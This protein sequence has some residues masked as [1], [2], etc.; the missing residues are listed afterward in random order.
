MKNFYS[1]YISSLGKVSVSA[2]SLMYARR[3]SECLALYE[4]IAE[5]VGFEGFGYR[6]LLI[7]NFCLR[8]MG[9]DFELE[10][11]IGDPPN[12]D[13]VGHL[14]NYELIRERSENA[15]VG[16]AFLAQPKVLHKAL[17]VSALAS[18]LGCEEIIETG[19]FLGESAYIFSGSVQTVT[20]IEADE[21]LHLTSRQWL[22]RMKSGDKI[23]CLCGDSGTILPDLLATA[24]RKLM[25]F[26]DAHFSAGITSKRF[27]ETPLE[28]ELKSIFIHS[29][30]SIVVIDD[31]RLMAKPGYPG[32]ERMFQLIPS[33]KVVSVEH[34][35]VIIQ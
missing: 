23:R 27:G 15:S 9:Q 12:A 19:T 26:L 3:F 32:W 30:E 28:R 1:T 29:P 6:D 7:Y 17:F 21:T 5:H 18:R 34:D 10:Q 4:N 14:C 16:T 33:G 11:Y 2:F 35:Q 25:I 8:Q 24:S 13:E 22:S 31:A 20:T